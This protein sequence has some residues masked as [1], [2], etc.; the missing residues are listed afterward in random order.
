MRTGAAAWSA[1][2]RV[3]CPV[4][5]VPCRRGPTMTSAAVG[6]TPCGAAPEQRCPAA[7]PGRSPGCVGRQDFGRLLTEPALI[8]HELARA[9]GGEWRPPALQ[10]RRK[11]LRDALTQ[12]ATAAGALAGSL[13]GGAHRARRVR[14]HTT[15]GAP[16]PTRL[17]SAVA[18]I[19]TRRRRTRC[20]SRLWP[21]DPQRVAVRCSRPWP[22]SRVP[23]ADNW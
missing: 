4:W 15:G 9:H 1:V 11:T 18:S 3:S 12:S 14:A 22:H 20:I 5:G 17:V 8:T 2:A 10:A 13:S 7:C 23:N 21:G 6:P 19:W 16:D